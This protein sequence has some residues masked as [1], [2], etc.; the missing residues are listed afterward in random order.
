MKQL[1]HPALAG[2]CDGRGLQRAI[3]D[4]FAA[5]GVVERVQILA[6]QPEDGRILA[7]MVDMASPAEAMSAHSEFGV[8]V[9]GFRTL[10]FSV[11][12]PEDFESGPI[13]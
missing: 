8:T 2:V 5:F 6:G 3:A 10:V 13:P 9:F 1:S 12:V 4:L 7:C 11:E